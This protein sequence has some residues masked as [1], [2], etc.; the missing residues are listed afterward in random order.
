VVECLGSA[1]E[2]QLWCCLPLNFIAL[3]SE[4]AGTLLICGCCWYLAGSKALGK[5]VRQASP[6][7]EKVPK[8]LLG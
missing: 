1:S 3:K 4:L 6:W 2:Y 8:E 5:K 7:E